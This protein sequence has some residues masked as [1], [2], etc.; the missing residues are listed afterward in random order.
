MGRKVG[1][2][3]DASKQQFG[4]G[5]G[6]GRC[7]GGRWQGERMEQGGRCLCKDGLLPVT[8]GKSFDRQREGATCGNS[9]VSS[10]NDPEIGHWW[11]DQSHF[12]C[13]KDS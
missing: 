13:F 8:A 6:G 2:I 12:D 7:G 1:F 9:T 3:L 5:C 11:S 10:D 4:L